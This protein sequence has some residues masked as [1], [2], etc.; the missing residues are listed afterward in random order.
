MCFRDTARGREV[1]YE[2]GWVVDARWLVFVAA[3]DSVELY[4]TVAGRD[5]GIRLGVTVGS[6]RVYQERDSHGNTASL[7]RL[8]INNRGVIAVGIWIDDH[9]GDTVEYELRMRF[10]NPSRPPAVRLSGKYAELE[11][12]AARDTDRS[13][14]VPQTIASSA[15]DLRNWSVARGRYKVALVPDSMYQFCETPC[16]APRTLKLH[17]VERTV[18]RLLR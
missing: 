11:I 9:L 12:L 2:P 4:A 10:I 18:A 8:R 14:V 16:V 3:Q 5:E 17:H 7:A 15:T 1:D 6:E 13:S